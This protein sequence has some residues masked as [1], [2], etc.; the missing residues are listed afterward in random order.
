MTNEQRQGGRQGSNS[1][2]R[3]SLS[4]PPS[5]FYKANYAIRCRNLRQT[6][7]MACAVYLDGQHKDKR[8]DSVLLLTWKGCI[9]E[10]NDDLVVHRFSKE[11][12]GRYHLN[13][14][15]L[16]HDEDFSLIECNCSDDSKQSKD[17]WELVRLEINCLEREEQMRD[18]QVYTT[19]GV[20]CLTLKLAYDENTSNHD[21]IV[22]EDQFDLKLVGAPIIDEDKCFVG[23]LRK[24]PDNA[25][26]L[27]PCF[28]SKGV[29]GE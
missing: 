5:N 13:C 3:D 19:N 17:T 12:F 22:D 11:H 16:F 27:I 15:R 26:Q 2:L 6:K 1:R 9:E 8:R 7:G 20:E 25:D 23:V 14:S 24:D 18:F 29:L 21:I 10:T 28:I 4:Y